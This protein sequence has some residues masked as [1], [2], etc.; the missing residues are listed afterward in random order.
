[1][2]TTPRGVWFPDD[3]NAISP[4]ESLFS[5]QA[6][7]V[8]A[9]GSVIQDNTP[10]SV[11]NATERDAFF[12]TP[13]AGDR[14]FRRDTMWEE[15]YLDATWS[16]ETGWFPVA[17]R[18]P[19]CFMSKASNQG[20]TGSTF[21]TISFATPTTNIQSGSF[22]PSTGSITLPFTGLWSFDLQLNIG[23]SS[24]GGAYLGVASDR[25]TISGVDRITRSSADIV[26]RQSGIILGKSI[27][28][29]LYSER[30]NVFVTSWQLGMSYLGP[31]K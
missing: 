22:T 21:A 18:T 13:A 23:S 8:D 10:Y 17:G 14:A 30:G 31:S 1:M 27:S 5:G 4:I 25:M 29:N 6:T 7:S 2:P 26:V 3:T 28:A 12:G 9:M 19:N 11:A 24:A 16:Y 15:L 20:L